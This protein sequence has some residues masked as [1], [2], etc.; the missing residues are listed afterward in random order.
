MESVGPTSWRVDSHIRWTRTIAGVHQYGQA[1]THIGSMRCDTEIL[2]VGAGPTGL[3][4]ALQSRV[5]GAKVRIIE[6]TQ[7]APGS[8]APALAVQPRTME[9]LRALG[10]SDPLLQRS[11]SEVALKV[12]G[13][14]WSAEGSL[15]HLHLP[16]TQLPF[17][18][19]TTQPDV[20]AVLRDRLRGVR[21]GGRMGKPTDRAG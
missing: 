10:V 13:D 4:L 18:L 9:V 12:H 1:S 5:S 2:V 6:Q 11:P 8:W 14:G 19:F 7:R 3:A 16:A 15:H 20:E 17:I 21:G